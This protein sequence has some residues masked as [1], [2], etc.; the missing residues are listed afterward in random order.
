[1]FVL[2]LEGIYENKMFGAEVVK[3]GKVLSISL[4]SPLYVNGLFIFRVQE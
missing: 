3:P 2:E 1:M 4:C